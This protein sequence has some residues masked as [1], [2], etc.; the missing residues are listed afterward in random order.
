MMVG[1]VIKGISK[2]GIPLIYDI[3]QLMLAEQLQ[4]ATKCC[5]SVYSRKIYKIFESF[6]VQYLNMGF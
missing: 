3:L 4:Y 5:S 2:L 6:P 1:G